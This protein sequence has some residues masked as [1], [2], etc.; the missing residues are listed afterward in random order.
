MSVLAPERTI[1]V[2]VGVQKFG[3]SIRNGTTVI[4]APGGPVY[5]Y[6]T[7]GSFYG[8]AATTACKG[9]GSMTS[10]SNLMKFN[11]DVFNEEPL[12]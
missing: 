1:Q 7:F 11:V 6:T 9:H 5:L 3:G 10:T 2:C 8:Y 4:P 12:S